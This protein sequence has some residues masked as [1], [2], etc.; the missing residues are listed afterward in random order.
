MNT[1]VSKPKF[2]TDGWR[3]IIGEDFNSFNCLLVV[4]SL[5]KLSPNLKKI[6][7][8]YDTRELSYEISIKIKKYLFDKGIDT[9]LSSCPIP[10][11]AVSFSVKNKGADLGII[12]TASHNSKIWN[13]IKIKNK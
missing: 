11:P 13:G 1:N 5:L 3:G 10:T 2:G 4:T 9:I 6:I 8:G 7:I 12:I